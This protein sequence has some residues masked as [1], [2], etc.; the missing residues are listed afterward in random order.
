L[1]AG[2][3]IA[4]IAILLAAA[5]AQEIEVK[6][7]AQS[8]IEE[9]LHAFSTDNIK[10]EA[11]LK[12]LFEAAGCAGDALTEHP[13]PHVRAPNVVCT[14]PGA[15]AAT[16]AVG[17]HFDMVDVGTGVVDNWSGA[18]LLPSLFQALGVSRH[19]F[20]F[21]GFTGEEKGLLGSKQLVREID[22]SKI[23]AM[24]NMDTLGLGETKVWTSHADPTL[25]RWL[26]ATANMMKIPV[27]TVN[28][29]KVGSSDSEPFRERKIP[30]ITIHS[31]TQPTLRILHSPNDT[32]KQ[33]DF[34]AYYRTYQ[35]VLGYLRVLD[36]K[37]D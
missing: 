2:C 20:W 32:I 1:G 15:S 27:E 12:Q 6:P 18:S 11:A 7:V 35:L 24:V 22:R 17:A 33:I 13:V 14:H 36:L 21:V 3:V 10:R 4:P 30:A 9:R 25:V 16:I 31:L 8:V 5:A 34:D 29:D 19:A 28:V 37:L 23:V 26:G